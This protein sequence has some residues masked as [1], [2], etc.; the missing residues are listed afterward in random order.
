[1][2]RG[3]ER[4]PLHLFVP[5]NG[6]T[7]A[8]RQTASCPAH[9]PGRHM[10][11]RRRQLR[12]G[13]TWGCVD[14]ASPAAASILRRIGDP[15][16][17]ATPATIPP[18]IYYPVIRSHL[19]SPHLCCHIKAPL[20]VLP[21]HAVGHHVVDPDANAC[22]SK[23]PAAAGSARSGSARRRHGWVPLNATWYQVSS[24]TLAR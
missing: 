24:C 17:K 10:E 14:A 2:K 20:D 9:L 11:P 8:G 4:A 15:I 23:P 19:S 21:T 3:A 18:A 1:M 13:R 6:I 22:A 12:Q 5:N 7:G 16:R